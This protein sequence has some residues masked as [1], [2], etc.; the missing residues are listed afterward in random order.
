MMTVCSPVVSEA[1]CRRYKGSKPLRCQKLYSCWVRPYDTPEIVW[2]TVM[3]KVW[4]VWM[5]GCQKS[6]EKQA[7]PASISF[8]TLAVYSK[9][10]STNFNQPSFSPSLSLHTL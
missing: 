8:I 10:R 1:L 7:V 3:T 9:Y 2:M 6:L 4:M 5:K